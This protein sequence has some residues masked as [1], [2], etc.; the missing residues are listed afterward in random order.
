M[1]VLA[2]GVSACGGSTPPP[3]ATPESA[4]PTAEATAQSDAPSPTSKPAGSEDEG[5][6]GEKTAK[7]DDSAAAA[8]E[9]APA[10]GKAPE[11]RTM[12]VIRK[13]VM[14]H[15]KA[16][17]QCYDD[18]RKDDKSLQGDV[19]IHFVL[20]PEGKVKSAALNQERSTL[21]A[22]KVVDCV[23]GVIK[24]IRGGPWSRHARS[25]ASTSWNCVNVAPTIVI[26]RTAEGWVE[27]FA[28]AS[29]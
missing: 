7:A 11:T 19:V 27:P 13:I 23:I 22:P 29:A 18:A 8:A 14:D 28:G 12:D 25:S 6:V 2:L 3:A 15:R 4:A 26:G 21:K 1:L 20:N 16:A 10:D 5:W 17:R 9:P 24:S